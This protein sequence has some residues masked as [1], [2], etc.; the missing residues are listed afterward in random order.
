[1]AGYSV[2]RIEE[3]EG[4]GPRGVFK[5]ARGELG[6]TAFGMAVIEMPPN[7][8]GYPEHSHS[9]DGQE[10]VYTAITGR[11][12][13]EIEGERHPIDPDTMIRVGPGVTRKVWTREEP[14]R[15]LIIGGAPGRVYE[16]PDF[17]ELGAPDPTRATAN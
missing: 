16:A 15:L 12:E 1:M 13:I 9:E 11:G 5:R 7:A 14:M 6:V 3:M 10:E 8:D 2:K 4:I 17:S